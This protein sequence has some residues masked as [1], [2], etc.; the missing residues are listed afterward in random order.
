MDPIF[1]LISISI[2]LNFA[3]SAFLVNVTH[4]YYRGQDRVAELEG[5]LARYKR[6]AGFLKEFA[7]EIE[8]DIDHEQ[9]IR[10]RDSIHSTGVSKLY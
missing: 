1:L 4:K 9:T 7:A 8:G 10:Q 3:L 2:T 5:Y 6:T